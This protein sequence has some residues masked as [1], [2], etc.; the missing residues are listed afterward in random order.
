LAIR[1]SAARTVVSYLQHGHTIHNACLAVAD[2]IRRLNRRYPAAITVHGIDKYG[3]HAA[4]CIGDGVKHYYVWHEGSEH[5]E[6]VATHI[7]E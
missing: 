4:V 2:E 7:I 6:Q 5:A 3:E 1:T